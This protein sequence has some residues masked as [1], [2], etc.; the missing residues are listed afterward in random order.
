MINMRYLYE[1]SPECYVQDVV[2]LMSLTSPVD[3]YSV[4]D[5]YDIKVHYEDINAAEAYLIVASG[6]KPIIINTRRIQYIPRQRLTIAHKI[7]HFFI[8]SQNP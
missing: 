4:C 2:Y 1:N 5:Y 3:I 6:K 8:S 7:G